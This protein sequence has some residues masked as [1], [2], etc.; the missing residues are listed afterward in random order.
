M[1]LIDLRAA[2]ATHYKLSS[3]AFDLF[4]ILLAAFIIF[5]VWRMVIHNF[6]EKIVYKVNLFI[7]I[8]VV[9]EFL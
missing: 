6:K 9:F 5:I 3:L 8:I 4:E 1:Y 7:I 2:G